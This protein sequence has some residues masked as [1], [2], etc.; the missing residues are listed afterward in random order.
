MTER[1]GQLYHSSVEGDA[2]SSRLCLTILFTTAAATLAA[3]RK[4]N[5]LA[6]GLESEI[7]VLAPRVIPYPLPLEPYPL[8]LDPLPIGRPQ[9]CL[10]FRLK[11]FH[12][13]CAREAT[14]AQIEIRLCRDVRDCLLRSLPV[15]SL[16]LIG[17]R[18]GWWPFGSF[19]RWSR[20]LKRAG[21]EVIFVH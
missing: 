7:L 10:D 8:P 1:R 6:D 15:H 11:Q 19:G 4:A 21:H 14:E 5:E 20:A 3:L 9:S 13:C 17:A 16:V 18:R 12:D 2:I